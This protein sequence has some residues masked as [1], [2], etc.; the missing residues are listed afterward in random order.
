MRGPHHEKQD[1]IALT[2]GSTSVYIGITGEKCEISGITIEQTDEV[3]DEKSIPRISDEISYIDHMESDIKNIQI[4]QTRSAATEGIELKNRLRINFHAMSLPVASFIW[5]CPYIAIF[6]SD[7]GQVFGENYHEY[8][9]IKINGE[10][11]GNED[12]AV[13]KLSMK[14]TEAFP[15][16]EAWKKINK[17]GLECRVELIRKG[18]KITTLTSNLGI[19]IENITVINDDNK[20]VYAAVTGDQIALTDI[21]VG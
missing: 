7:D 19:S 10:S 15:G 17:E 8:A 5:H 6:S 16:W 21:R 2:D 14:K 13:N 11:S 12:Y 9:L 20:T 18:N 3:V 4:S 1:I